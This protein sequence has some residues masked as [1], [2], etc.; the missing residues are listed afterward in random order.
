MKTD[1]NAWRK[2][3]NI[4]IKHTSANSKKLI[5]DEP[6]IFHFGDQPSDVQLILQEQNNLF[7]QQ[8]FSWNIEKG[9]DPEEDDVE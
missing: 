7:R 5:K 1:V 8:S 4:L 6:I 3:E 2:I 9:V